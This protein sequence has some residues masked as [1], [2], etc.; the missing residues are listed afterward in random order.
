VLLGTCIFLHSILSALY[1]EVIQRSGDAITYI[2]RIHSLGGN[3][4][5]LSCVCRVVHYAMLEAIRAVYGIW[6]I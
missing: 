2:L 6:Q 4:I 3:T 1:Y 5:V